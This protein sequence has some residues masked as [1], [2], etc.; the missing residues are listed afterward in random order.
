VDAA[1]AGLEALRRE[2][3]AELEAARQ[4]AAGGEAPGEACLASELR[5]ELAAAVGELGADLEAL[6]GAQQALGPRVDELRAQLG[7][8]Q[9]LAGEVAALR[10]ELD[11]LGRPGGAVGG[12]AAAPEAA[13]TAVAG[14]AAATADEEAAAKLAAGEAAAAKAAEAEQLEA[15]LVLTYAERDNEARAVAAKEDVRREL[16]ASLGEWRDEAAAL[17]SRLAELEFAAAEAEPGLVE[18]GA[19]AGDPGA[20]AEEATA[21]GEEL[22]GELRSDVA[23]LRAELLSQ[24]AR[25]AERDPAAAAAEAQNAARIAEEN[26][27]AGAELRG[28]VEA[29]EAGACEP[30]TRIGE[31]AEQV[32][33]QAAVTAGLTR[34]LGEAAVAERPGEEAST[35]RADAGSA[36]A[37]EAGRLVAELA[38]K[39]ER[40]E[41]T[42]AAASAMQCEAAAAQVTAHDGAIARLADELGAESARQEDATGTLRALGL[43]LREEVSQLLA[44]QKDATQ[45]E[46]QRGELEAPLGEWH[47][48]AAALGSRLAELEFAAA[49]AEPGLV[50]GGAGGGAEA[51]AAL[52]AVRNQTLRLN[53]L[54]RRHPTAIAELPAAAGSLSF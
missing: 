2:T 52:E 3:Q 35:A 41:D 54:P 31:L 8:A 36:E 32:A 18:G 30:A 33:A 21:L 22:R 27:S 7:P 42:V 48:E 40:L 38:L 25:Q 34:Q 28:R 15:M 26:A 5:S 50:E 19:G 17:G 29:L 20:E 51:T 9:E 24:L 13:A 37:S 23:A 14:G 6:R 49:E 45:R 16:E 11:A 46:G 47:D 44:W 1:G 43:G 10:A 12:A 53:P 4:L 39:H